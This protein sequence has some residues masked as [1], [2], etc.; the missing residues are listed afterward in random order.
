MVREPGSD[1]KSTRDP[2][3]ITQVVLFGAPLSEN[4]ENSILTSK[5]RMNLAD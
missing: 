5:A 3:K 1:G 2:R 4:T